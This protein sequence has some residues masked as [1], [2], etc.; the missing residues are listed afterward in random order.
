MSEN[1]ELDQLA[2]DVANDV[3]KMANQMADEETFMVSEDDPDVEV[4]D[5][6]PVEEI[7][8]HAASPNEEEDPS[9]G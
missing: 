8:A 2:E 3:E 1:T 6:E 5:A 9:D 7:P 4:I